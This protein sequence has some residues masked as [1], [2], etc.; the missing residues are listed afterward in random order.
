M[1]V[2]LDDTVGGGG[3]G[4]CGRH[5]YNLMKDADSYLVKKSEICLC[6]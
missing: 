1:N 3:G 2:P 4:G 6:M 5:I